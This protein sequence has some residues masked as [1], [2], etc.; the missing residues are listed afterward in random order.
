MRG[1]ELSCVFM[2]DLQ[3]NT[4]KFYRKLLSIC[5]LGAKFVA[6]MYYYCYFTLLYGPRAR[7]EAGSSLEF[8]DAHTEAD[9]CEKFMQKLLSSIKVLNSI[10]LN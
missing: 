5:T 8:I 6:A 9:C 7:G 10:L 1:G 3:R 4:K 2:A